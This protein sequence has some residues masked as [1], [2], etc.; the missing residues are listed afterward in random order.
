MS[1]IGLTDEERAVV[2]LVARE[3]DRRFRS[4][5]DALAWYVPLFAFALYGL[6]IKDVSLIFLSLLFLAVLVVWAL[7]SSNADRR[8]LVAIMT[9]I[10]D[11][12]RAAATPPP[13]AGTTGPGEA[14][15]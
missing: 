10:D 3:R 12:E 15:G 8:R 4:F 6:V 9:K 2:A 1:R 13:A 11:Y 5:F 14:T 7:W